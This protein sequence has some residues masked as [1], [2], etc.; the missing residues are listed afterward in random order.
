MHAV[1]FQPL[2]LHLQIDG[3]W[4]TDPTNRRPSSQKAWTAG[5][6]PITPKSPAQPQQNGNIL[7]DKKLF[8]V[9]QPQQ[10]DTATPDKHAND[11]LVF[12]L[13][14]A[15]VSHPPLCFTLLLTSSTR[16]RQSPS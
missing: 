16:E 14:A 3:P 13:A 7:Q 8:A 9:E 10:K 11:R 15:I 2:D 4:L 1:P 6:N 5:A 12:I